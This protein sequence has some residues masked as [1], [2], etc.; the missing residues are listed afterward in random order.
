MHTMTMVSTG[1]PSTGRITMR[2]ISRPPTNEMTRVAPNAT[3]YGRPALSSVHA[4]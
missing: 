2:S 3:Q 1:A 4:R